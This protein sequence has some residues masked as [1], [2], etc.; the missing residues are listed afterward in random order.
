[1]DQAISV[2]FFLFSMFVFLLK[3]NKKNKEE[4]ARKFERQ[5]FR[6]QTD[7]GEFSTSAVTPFVGKRSKA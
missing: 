5:N 3:K 6:S 4:F 1:M 7:A 2:F